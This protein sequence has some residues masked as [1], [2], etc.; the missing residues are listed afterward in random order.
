M[1]PIY[2]PHY[3]AEP[4]T[5]TEGAASE[6][7]EGTRTKAWAKLF[8]TMKQADDTDSEDEA[9]AA[10]A[11]LTGA[12]GILSAW[13]GSSSSSSAAAAALPP[14]SISFKRQLTERKAPSSITTYAADPQKGK[15]MEEAVQLVLGGA[16]AKTMARLK[17]MDDRSL[18]RHVETARANGGKGY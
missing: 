6:A 16:P 17:G 4:G 3:Q 12:S 2:Q 13:S 1:I 8:R 10:L 18:R 14:S 5:G 9:G 15:A 7:S 11:A